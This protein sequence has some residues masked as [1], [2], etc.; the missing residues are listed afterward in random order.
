VRYRLTARPTPDSVGGAVQRCCSL[1]RRSRRRSPQADGK[2]VVGGEVAVAMGT[3]FVVV[4]YLT[5]GARHG[6]A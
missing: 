2:I 5:T 1:V 3:A 6:F 4:R